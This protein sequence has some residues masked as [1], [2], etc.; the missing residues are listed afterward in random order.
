M[1][2]IVQLINDNR[3]IQRVY[4]SPSPFF[5]PAPSALLEGFESLA[6]H[7]EIHV[8]SCLQRLPERSPQKLA[9]N[10]FFH[11]LHVPRSGWMRSGYAGCI[12]AVRRK[13]REIG[14]DIVHGQGSERDCAI[15]A[16]HAGRTAVITLHGVMSVLYPNLKRQARL[17]YAMARALEKYSVKRVAGVVCISDAV[18]SA[19]GSIARRTW[20]IPNAIRGEFLKRDHG[21]IR[22][23]S[24]APHF[25]NVGLISPLK[26][27]R[28]LLEILMPLRAQCPFKTTFVGRLDTGSS[29][30]R[31]FAAAL[32]Q[33]RAQYG[34][35]E[36]VPS[37]NQAELREAF[38]S[39]DALLHFSKEE[40]F[41][42]VLAE[43][44]ARQLPVF[45]TKV[46]AADELCTSSRENC[47][48]YP[49][50]GASEMQAGLGAWLARRASLAG[51]PAAPD[52]NI[53]S[54]M[55]PSVVAARHLRVYAEALAGSGTK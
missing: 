7:T 3:E 31:S 24:S 9:K 55:S 2:R 6:D 28:E 1:L 17:Y 25:I 39:A 30:G 12:L 13:V 49:V 48:V 36:H 52:E 19:I 14:P 26:R 41:C 45:T 53:A 22:A 18:E 15:C 42:L 16:A 4:D 50:D 10:I 46:G 47:F 23:V 5:G 35:F 34:D 38:D 43:A 40:S 8:I 51:R 33:A 27:Q 29:Y 20:R 21:S 32:G 11:P 37:L 44:R 54:K